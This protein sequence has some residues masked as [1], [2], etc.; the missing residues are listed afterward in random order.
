LAGRWSKK[1]ISMLAG[2]LG[3][4]CMAV[5]CFLLSG[6]QLII[7]VFI[8]AIFISLSYPELYATFEDYI[9]RLGA[10]GQKMIGLES[11]AP[12]VAYV[13]GPILAGATITEFGPQKTLAFLAC[14]VGL[15]AVL[16]LAVVPRKIKMPHEWK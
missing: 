10:H 6:W 15:A 11:S 1:R 9:S 16:G 2:L 8:S 3:A 14:G 13:I 5:T 4:I 12:N 7:G